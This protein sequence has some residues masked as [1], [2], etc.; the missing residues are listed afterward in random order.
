MTPETLGTCIAVQTVC[1]FVVLSEVAPW[2]KKQFKTT[3]DLFRGGGIS[4][5]R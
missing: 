2:E 5:A 4:L 1:V 3:F